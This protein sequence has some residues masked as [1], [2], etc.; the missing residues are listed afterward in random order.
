MVLKGFPGIL[1]VLVFSVFGPRAY[2]KKKQVP[3][4]GDRREGTQPYGFLAWI[5]PYGFRIKNS[6]RRRISGFATA[7]RRTCAVA[8]IRPGAALRRRFTPA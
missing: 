4:L 7:I 3:A 1:G 6:T 2:G 8:I 5:E